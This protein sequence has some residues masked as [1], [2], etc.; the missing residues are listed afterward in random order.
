MMIL[1]DLLNVI[2]HSEFL[3]VID[4]HGNEIPRYD[5]VHDISRYYAS[6]EIKRI[7]TKRVQNIHA[8]IIELK[9]D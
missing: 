1:N 3:I 9:E 8:L 2:D 6:R 4:G 7:Y 5:G